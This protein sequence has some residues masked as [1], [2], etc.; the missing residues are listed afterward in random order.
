MWHE[1]KKSEKKVMNMMI[2]MQKRAERRRAYYDKLVRALYC[3]IYHLLVYL[4]FGNKLPS[5]F[6]F[7][8]NRTKTYLIIRQRQT[9]L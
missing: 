4:A 9:V 7:C 5:K 2:D 6:C 3:G 8:R 1:A